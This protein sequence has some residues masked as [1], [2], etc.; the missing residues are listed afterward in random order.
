[1][2][3]HS[4]ECLALGG[5]SMVDAMFDAS[6]CLLKR[7]P[8]TWCQAAMIISLSRRIM[9]CGLSEAGGKWRAMGTAK[10]A[11]AAAL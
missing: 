6:S 2:A 10:W 9:A 5:T 7:M 11:V 1:M 3:R 8:E 4:R